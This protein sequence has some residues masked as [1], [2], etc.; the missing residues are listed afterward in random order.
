MGVSRLEA[1]DG[2]V[3]SVTGASPRKRFG[4]RI[5]AMM[6]DSIRRLEGLFVDIVYHIDF[7]LSA[8]VSPGKKKRSGEKAGI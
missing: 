3:F 6:L 2:V 7:G 8:G 5:E 4:R 1:H